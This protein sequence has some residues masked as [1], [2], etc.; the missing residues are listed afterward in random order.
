MASSKDDLL[1]NIELLALDRQ[2]LRQACRQIAAEIC[3][4]YYFQAYGIE[5]CTKRHEVLTSAK[6]VCDFNIPEMEVRRILPPVLEASDRKLIKDALAETQRKRLRFSRYRQSNQ[7]FDIFRIEYDALTTLTWLFVSKRPGAKADAFEKD[8]TSVARQIEHFLDR[9]RSRQSDQAQK[10]ILDSFFDEESR[11]S[12]KRCWIAIVQALPNFL[13]PFAKAADTAAL[14]VELVVPDANLSGALR[15]VSATA[16]LH[17]EMLLLGEQSITGYLLDSKFDYLYV[18]PSLPRH[19]GRYRSYRF[20][21]GLARVEFAVALRTRMRLVAI[22]NFE[23]LTWGQFPLPLLNAFVEMSYFSTRFVD[24]LQSKFTDFRSQ[25]RAT[26]QATS[27]ALD[28][29]AGSFDHIVQN[30]MGVAKLQL[31]LLMYSPDKSLTQAN[32]ARVRTALKSI[33]S[34]IKDT[35]DFTDR[36]PNFLQMGS[37]STARLLE[38]I[39]QRFRNPQVQEQ[40]AIQ[41]EISASSDFII[42]A[43]QL[44]EAHLRNIVANA[45]RHVQDRLQ[46]LTSG[47][48]KAV[49]EPYKPTV[50]IE[51]SKH[52]VTDV[53]RRGIGLNRIT[54]AVEDNGGGAS[55][56]DLARLGRQPVAS[57]YGGQGWAIF[58]A[59]KYMT[60][61]DGSLKVSNGS[62]GGFRAVL[63]FQEFEPRLHDNEMTSS[64]D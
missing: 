34:G 64:A 47:R 45:K 11:L 38:R 55:E 3:Q 37:I 22:L 25:E 61:I 32:E 56:E 29:I 48:R 59:D 15:I 50:W 8:R 52:E 30:T 26:R 21:R 49:R 36:L 63:E 51:V 27:K 9:A 23:H 31:E 58:G 41:M 12:P 57:R 18:D 46:R 54:I 28:G 6:G 42:Y 14:A 13:S 40:E 20:S 62:R 10:Y 35:K 17:D 2:G 19:A 44:V 24:A 43:S 39:K 60:A 33:E 5:I 16:N 1:R 4:T 7:Q 53:Q